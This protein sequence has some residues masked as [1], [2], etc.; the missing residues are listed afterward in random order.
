MGALASLRGSQPVILPCLLA[1]SACATAIAP[2]V[3][4]PSLRQE[5]EEGRASWFLNAASALT[6]SFN[7]QQML[8]EIGQLVRAQSEQVA[9]ARRRLLA[10]LADA[11]ASGRFDDARVNA[12][13][14]EVVAAAR[15]RQP[16][17]VQALMQLHAGLSPTQ[18][19]SVVGSVREAMSNRSAQFKSERDQVRSRVDSV[20]AD[21][22][23]TPEQNSQ[24][25]ADIVEG[26]KSYA[27][28]LQEEMQARAKQLDALCQAFLGIYFEPAPAT[29]DSVPDLLAKSNRLIAFA[30]KL[31]SILTPKQ[32]ERVAAS[33]RQTTSTD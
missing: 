10:I 32:R 8:I 23:L 19:Q 14:D 1:L 29:V 30:R 12:G 25:Q 7:Q 31:T 11:I 6:L 3:P 20:T 9:A 4:A 26:F 16:A 17:V 33:L 21:V 5:L 2:S 27:P 13:L 18:R 15:A 28:D 24:L 22:G